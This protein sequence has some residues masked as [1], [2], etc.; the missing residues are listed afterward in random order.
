M[1]QLKKYIIPTPLP[2]ISAG[3]AHSLYTDYTQAWGWGY[4]LY[5]QLGNND[6]DDWGSFPNSPVAVCGDHTFCHIS[7]GGS[8]SLAIDQNGQAWGWARGANGRLGDNTETNRSTP[9]AV[10]GG[11]TFCHI[12]AGNFHSL[13]IDHSG[14]AWGWGYNYYGQIG[15]GTNTDRHT[16][17]RVCNL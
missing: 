10:C 11:H 9:V 2:L 16:P 15:D 4:N 12:S 6:T 3:N 17:V 13:A 8:H 7:A 14:Q 5:G 1:E